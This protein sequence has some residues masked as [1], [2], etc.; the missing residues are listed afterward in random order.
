MGF[1]LRRKRD[2]Q[3]LRKSK[4]NAKHAVLIV[5]PRKGYFA[6]K[7]PPLSIDKNRFQAETATMPHLA[8]KIARKSRHLFAA[9]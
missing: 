5:A 3:N 7:H 1:P 9:P 2:I 8:G 4:C 6:R